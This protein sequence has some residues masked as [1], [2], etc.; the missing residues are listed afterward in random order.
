MIRNT[1][2]VILL[3][4][5]AYFSYKY[6]NLMNQLPQTVYTS[7]KDTIVAT[8]DSTNYVDSQGIPHVISPG[9]INP[10]IDQ[11]ATKRALEFKP[12]IDKVAE[13]APPQEKQIVKVL[14]QEIKDSI[15]E[16]K[17]QLSNQQYLTFYYKDKYLSLGLKG[18]ITD[19]T[20]SLESFN[21]NADL[22]IKQQYKRNKFLG[23]PI[24]AN[25]SY[26][27]VSSVDP[28]VTIQGKKDYTVVQKEP[29][30]GLRLQALGGYNF[31]TK[32]L[33][34]GPSLRVDFL[35]SS[36]RGSYLYNFQTKKWTPTATFEK[37][38]IRF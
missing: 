24:G 25:K 29:E 34:T 18:N 33:S 28:R 21:Y 17:Q 7:K 27:T 3:I 31:S 16:L 35:K 4:T 13:S 37:D 30:F 36:L 32:G 14:P 1:L 19:T 26:L 22:T 2:I 5:S 6:Y 23:V 9:Q 20:S 8:I 12:I 11:E 15:K 10:I 38:I